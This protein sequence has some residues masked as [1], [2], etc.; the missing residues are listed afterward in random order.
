M[1]TKNWLPPPIHTLGPTQWMELDPGVHL[2]VTERPVQEGGW[3]FEAALYR[4]CPN[5]GHYE[6]RRWW[7]RAMANAILTAQALLPVVRQARGCGNTCDR[8][9]K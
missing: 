3:I 1:Q 7:C 8:E 9:G 6:I 4:T 5:C 2:V